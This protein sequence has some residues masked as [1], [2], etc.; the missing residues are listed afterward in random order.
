MPKVKLTAQ[1]LWNGVWYQP[2][3]AVEVP[4]DLALSLG[5]KPPA[6]RSS[7]NKT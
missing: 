2:G 4:E 1:T 3:D 5:L 7:S 6:P